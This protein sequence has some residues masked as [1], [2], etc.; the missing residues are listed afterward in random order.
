LGAPSSNATWFSNRTTCAIPL[1]TGSQSGCFLMA[2]S[3]V[4]LEV[5][6]QLKDL[7]P[8][9]PKMLS[10]G[11]PDILATAEQIDTTCGKDFANSLIRRDD[12]DEIIAWHGLTGKLDF[13]ADSLNFFSALNIDCHTIDI[14]ASRGNE[15]IIDLNEPLPQDLLASFDLVFDPGTLEH[16]FNIGQASINAAACLKVNGF[17][18]HFSPL[19]MFNHGFFN[20]NP[21]FF[22]NFYHQN[23]FKIVLMKGCAGPI[24]EQKYFDLPDTERFEG[25][26]NDASV[27]AVAQRLSDQEITFPTQTKY[28]ENPDLKS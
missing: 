10:L 3:H 23:G 21:T 6:A 7:L 5:L 15:R 13:I 28:L 11:Y 27:V 20:L 14:T 8:A 12:S 22:F 18:C 2:I 26:P 17:I 24:L 4:Q 16:C 9:V 25:V 1:T 19:S